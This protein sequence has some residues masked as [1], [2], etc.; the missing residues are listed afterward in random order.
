MNEQ[1]ALYLKVKFVNVC[2]KQGDYNSFNNDQN[3]TYF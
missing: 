3:N 2:G 1:T